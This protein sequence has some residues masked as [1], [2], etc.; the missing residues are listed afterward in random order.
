MNALGDSAQADRPVVHRVEGGHDGQQ[1]LGGANVAG[2]LLPADVLLPG[3]HRHAQRL[4]APAINR[5]SYDAAG[6]RAFVTVAGGK[7]GGVGPAKT[8]GNTEA[9]GVTHHHVGAQ[10][11][12]RFHQQQRHDVGGNCDQGIRLMGLVD[13][14]GNILQVTVSAGV[15]Q[16]QPKGLGGAQQLIRLTH[17]H[18]DVQRLGAGFHHG[19]GLGMAIGGH[20]ECIAAITLVHPVQQGHGLGGGG[21]LVQH[22][23]VRQIHAGQVQN[24][25]LEG[26]QRFQPALGDFRL[27]GC[28]GCIPAGVLQHIALYDG[29]G[30]CVVVTGADKGGVD[31]VLAGQPLQ[32]RQCGLLGLRAR[33]VHG[34][35]S[36]NSGG[37]SIVDQRVEVVITYGPGHL[38]L[39]FRG[40]SDMASDELCVVFQVRQTGHRV[41]GCGRIS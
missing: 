30:P 41:S 25:L 40:G 6:C 21:T 10:G 13:K 9:L 31:H 19:D 20:Q 26:E 3:L 22:G 2:G 37:H 4:I 11:A 35:L 34:L 14:P 24:H 23:G 27:V 38:C 32:P 1:C 33:Q 39:L 12:G 7:I 36:A 17:K 18:L 29:R 8:H 16:Q 28:I 5:N 15:L